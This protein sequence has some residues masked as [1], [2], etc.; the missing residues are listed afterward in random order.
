MKK[1]L[2]IWIVIV[3]LVIV[4]GVIY[5]KNEK[6]ATGNSIADCYDICLNTGQGSTLQSPCYLQCN[7]KYGL[8][9]N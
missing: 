8:P 3:I 6:R 4:L 9:P 7:E 1:Y 5:Y 2:W